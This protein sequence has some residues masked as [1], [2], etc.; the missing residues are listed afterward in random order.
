MLRKA[1]FVTLGLASLAG[2]ATAGIKSMDVKAVDI[3]NLTL[4]VD[5]VWNG[6]YGDVNDPHSPGKDFGYTMLDSGDTSNTLWINET[7]THTHSP[8]AVLN[9]TVYNEGRSDPVITINK[10][11][12]NFTDFAWTGFDIVL[13]T[14]SGNIGLVG[15][16]TSTD[17]A[18]A[19]VFNMNSPTVLM[20]FSNGSVNPG[21][22]VVFN[23]TFTVP[24]T[25]L[26]T[27]TITQTPIPSPASL[28]IL[29]V[30]G[31]FASRRTRVA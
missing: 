11:V 7:W 29:A 10:S 27:F 6:S 16:P 14:G 31:V 18:N 30:G 15:L 26:W 13:S 24:Y 19:A 4:P 3:D 2:T 20:T 17:F 8:S 22:T 21:E 25:G 9:T 23:F 12:D 1:V 28:A 5:N